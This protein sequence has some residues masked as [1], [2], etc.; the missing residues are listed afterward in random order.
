MASLPSGKTL[1][2]QIKADLAAKASLASPA[3]TGEP[4]APTP[5]TSDNSTRVATTSFV[6]SRVKEAI[7]SSSNVYL[8]PSMFTAAKRSITLPA[9]MDVQIGSTIYTTATA[10]IVSITDFGNVA[11][12][13]FYI[14][15]CVP[16]SGNEP[17]FVISQNSTVP[18]GY[19]ADESRKI[20]GF[21]TL[22]ADAGTL[23]Y[24]NSL[25]GST[26]THPL[27]GYVK[28]DILPKSCWDLWHRPQGDPEG[29]VYLGDNG[30]DVWISIYLLSWNGTKL[31]STY[32]GTTADGG[33]TKK[34]HGELFSEALQMQ[35]CRLPYRN[36]FVWAARGAN[37]QTNIKG[38]AD[39]TTT[40]GHTDTAGRRML[41]NIGCEDTCGFLWQWL[42]ELGFAGGSGWSDSFYNSGV[43]PRSYGQGYGTVYRL[44]AGGDWGS[45]SSCGSRSAS[46]LRAS[47]SVSANGGARGASEPLHANALVI[48][49]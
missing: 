13:N 20:G 26:V 36:E 40:G 38:S 14:Y 29:M 19:T 35:N 23:T 16:T 10:H 6:V 33:S 21:H 17:T 25:T 7:S 3:F 47:S 43:D 27:S 24:T 39:A 30:Q 41:S 45:S 12:G 11:G 9:N 32:G 37:E 22:C 34:W 49:G 15:A 46:A 42:Q 48:T 5:S 18:T 4:T 28:G 2:E 1:G 8:R 31:V 44:H